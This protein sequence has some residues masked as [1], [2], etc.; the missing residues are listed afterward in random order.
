MGEG[1]YWHLV[2][3]GQGCCQIAYNAL[4]S[5]PLPNKELSSPQSQSA[6]AGKPWA[7][8]SRA[9]LHQPLQTS[10]QQPGDSR[11]SARPGAGAGVCGA[12]RELAD[13][14]SQ[15]PEL[16]Q[17]RGEQLPGSSP[18]PAS[19]GW[20]PPVGGG[21]F[22]RPLE[23]GPG[24]SPRASAAD[25]EG[26][27]PLARVLFKGGPGPRRP[28]QP[29]PGTKAAWGG[30]AEPGAA[31]VWNQCQFSGEEGPP[32]SFPRPH[33]FCPQISRLP[34]RG[35]QAGAHWLSFVCRLKFQEESGE[36]WLTNSLTVLSSFTLTCPHR[37]LLSYPGCFLSFAGQIWRNTFH[38]CRPTGKVR[39]DSEHCSPFPFLLHLQAPQRLPWR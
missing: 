10:V 31:V 11:A 3:G 21:P 2:G 39:I 20:A 32:A 9:G 18:P 24:P 7:K 14:C 35:E 4:D 1:F 5:P 28:P 34:R 16:A 8:P 15:C 33:C 6:N 19:G 23:G 12:A 38:N 37:H 30:S 27:R 22:L 13:A 36:Q 26:P 17:A 29:V 25:S